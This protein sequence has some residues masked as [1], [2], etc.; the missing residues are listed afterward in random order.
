M[1]L[2]VACRRV[3]LAEMGYS[4]TSNRLIISFDVLQ[5]SPMLCVAASPEFESSVCMTCSPPTGSRARIATRTLIHEQ[6]TWILSIYPWWG[7]ALRTEAFKLTLDKTLG[8]CKPCTIQEASCRESWAC[9]VLRS[10]KKKTSRACVGVCVSIFPSD[11]R[12]STPPLSMDLVARGVLRQY[13]HINLVT[14]QT[15]CYLASVGL[16]NYRAMVTGIHVR[17]YYPYTATYACS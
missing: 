11:R 14:Q 12:A 6:R 2:S 4:N 16:H 3:G 8:M 9:W 10:E 7:N 13:I 17:K 1:A 15:M 5:A